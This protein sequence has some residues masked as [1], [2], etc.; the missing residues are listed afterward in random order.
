M[1]DEQPTDPRRFTMHQ[2]R[3]FVDVIDHGLDTPEP[4]AVIRMS[5]SIGNPLARLL[6]R[7]LEDLLNEYPRQRFGERVE[8][9]GEMGTIVRCGE[10]GGSGELHALDVLPEPVEPTDA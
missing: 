9:G 10:C 6:A 5:R 3:E 4:V 7:F 8:D 2:T 1:T